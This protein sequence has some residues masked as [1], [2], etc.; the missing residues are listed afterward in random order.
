MKQQS[1]INS[2][3]TCPNIGRETIRRKRK[4]EEMNFEFSGRQKEKGKIK[5]N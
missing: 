5:V 3:D 4:V 1:Q 2:G